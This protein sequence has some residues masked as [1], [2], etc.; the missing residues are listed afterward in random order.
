MIINMVTKFTNIDP[1]D[2][3]SWPFGSMAR[4]TLV[5]TKATYTARDEVQ[6]ASTR[7]SDDGQK[8]VVTHSRGVLIMFHNSGF[9]GHIY[10]RMA[11]GQM[12]F[13]GP[14]LQFWVQTRLIGLFSSSYADP[15]KR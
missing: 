9:V 8:R 1:A 4:Y 15:T 10:L 13:S 6:E 3:W 14:R 5:P 12:T 11:L 7:Y 2:F